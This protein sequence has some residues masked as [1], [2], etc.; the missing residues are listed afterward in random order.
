MNTTKKHQCPSETWQGENI[1]NYKACLQSKIDH[2]ISCI[3]KLDYDDASKSP[4]KVVQT[5]GSRASSTTTTVVLQSQI[6]QSDMFQDLIMQLTSYYGPKRAFINIQTQ[7]NHKSGMIRD[8]D[9]PNLN[10]AFLLKKIWELGRPFPCFLS[11]FSETLDDIGM[12]CI[13][14]ISYRLLMDFLAFESIFFPN[15]MSHIQ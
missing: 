12:T 8:P 10:V 2:V 4:G 14:G 13:Q 3:L 1:H 5:R 6:V 7:F 15:T 11:H 9:F